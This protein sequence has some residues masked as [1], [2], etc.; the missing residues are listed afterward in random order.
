MV[1]SITG[2]GT[3]TKKSKVLI[4][5]TAEDF[6]NEMLQK[7]L[8]NKFPNYDV[9]VQ[10]VSTGNCVVKLKAEGTKIEADIIF[11]SEHTYAE[12]LK[13]YFYDLNDYDF[14]KHLDELVPS[15]KKY[16]TS[17]RYSGAIIINKK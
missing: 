12:S 5:S 1:V 4:Y 16:V 17:I 9:T 10:Y 15:D 13:Q 6:R 2:W 11:E 14:S 3:N 8:N 7:E